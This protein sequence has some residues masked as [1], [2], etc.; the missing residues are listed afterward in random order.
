ML[1][2]TASLA[3]LEKGVR[4]LKHE[5]IQN[6]KPKSLKPKTH[7]RSETYM[8]WIGFGIETNLHQIE[9]RFLF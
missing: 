4:G 6:P 3:L 1:E 8:S 9:M 7:T 5:T 2:V